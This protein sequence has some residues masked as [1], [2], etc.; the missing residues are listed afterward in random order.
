MGWLSENVDEV[1]AL[2]FAGAFT[3]ISIIL[4]LRGQMD[5]LKQFV[6]SWSP[7]MLPI[8]GFYFGRKTAQKTAQE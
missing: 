2:I 5:Q 6:E 1:I 3:A 4:A 7:V 8:V